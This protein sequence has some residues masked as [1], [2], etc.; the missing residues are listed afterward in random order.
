MDVG[1]RLLRDTKQRGG[2]LLRQDG[3]DIVDMTFDDDPAALAEALCQ[4][5]QRQFETDIVEQRGMQE[6][7]KGAYLL[8]ALLRQIEYFRGKPGDGIAAVP[9][10]IAQ[11]RRIER[12]DEQVLR[13]RVVKLAGNPPSLFILQPQDPRVEPG[14][15]IPRPASRR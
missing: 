7:G 6:V 5:S 1:E 8:D 11:A 3:S 14:E 15:L 2:D 4:P 9:V 13:R 10:R 12:D